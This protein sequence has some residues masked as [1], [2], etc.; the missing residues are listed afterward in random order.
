MK[1]RKCILFHNLSTQLMK[2]RSVTNEMQKI[3]PGCLIKEIIFL[4]FPLEMCSNRNK[5]KN[6]KFT[7][8]YEIRNSMTCNQTH[9]CTR[10]NYFLYMYISDKGTSS[11]YL[12]SN[13]KLFVYVWKFKGLFLFY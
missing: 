11:L 3:P 2:I 13:F 1:H 4:I 7:T 6:N 8:K 9:Y 12:A 10:Q 5:C